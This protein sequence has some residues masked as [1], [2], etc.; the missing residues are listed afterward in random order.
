MAQHATAGCLS[1]GVW[2]QFADAKPNQI[3]PDR[4]FGDLARRRVVLLGEVHDNEDHHRW[5]LQTIAALHAL[6]PKLVLGFEMFPRR[7][8]S[9]LDRWTAGKLSTAEFLERS[10]WRT[11]WGQE[12]QLYLPIFEFARMNR[13]PMIALNVDRKLVTTV[14]EKGWAQIPADQR[15]GIT[16]PAPAPPAYL[17]L[18]HQ[19][20]GEHAT[21]DGKATADADLDNPA[22][23]RF[24]D[25][26]LL[27]DRA[28][29]QGI[30]QATKQDD[31]A[32][33]VALM[34]SGHVQQ[35]F[36]VPRQLVDLGVSD[37][38]VLLPAETSA[39]CEDLD[40]HSATALFGIDARDDAEQVERPRLG[41]ALDQT[42]ERVRVQRVLDGSI[43][44]QA[45]LRADD[46]IETI[47]GEHVSKVDEVIAAVGR[48]APGTWLPIVVRR[49]ND[50]T[51]IIARFPPRSRR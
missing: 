39:S 41:V 18:L 27:W 51:E 48:Q 44:Q 40:D 12:P 9:V 34:G 10:E 25:S 8:Q 43:A 11:V 37:A 42:D 24:V 23:H 22:F 33:V 31:G 49:G 6:H 15:A 30:A 47:A 19:S 14:G 13:I 7:L 4:L 32:L 38:A 21:R 50:T 26:M 16:D 1:A 17:E 5:Q 3:A 20:Y 2:T 46:V 45:G 36:G 35:G 29:A 28:M